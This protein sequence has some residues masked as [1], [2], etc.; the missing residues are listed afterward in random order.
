MI[1]PEI[2][3]AVAATEVIPKPNVPAEAQESAAEAEP[4]IEPE[5]EAAAE[6]EPEI[7]MMD[8]NPYGYRPCVLRKELLV[9]GYKKQQERYINAK[10]TG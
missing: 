8:I 10:N 3:A 5:I 2:A 9:K 6:E 1:E 4:V 7:K